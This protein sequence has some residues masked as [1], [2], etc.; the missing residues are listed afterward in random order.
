M[1]TKIDNRN[2]TFNYEVLETLEA[3]LVLTGPEVK[4]VKS[5]SASLK[6]S[7]V[8]IDGHEEAWLVGCYIAP[9][10]PAGDNQRNYDPYHRRKLLLHKKEL[11]ELLGKSKQKGLTIIPTS[12]YTSKRLVKVRIALARGKTA[13]DKRETIKNRELSRQ[14]KKHLGSR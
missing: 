6:G 14:V 9:Y 12:V 1:S 5:G 10:R 7:Y 3:G 8:S 11:R 4:S 2:G 13:V